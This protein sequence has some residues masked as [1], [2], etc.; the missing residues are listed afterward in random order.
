MSFEPLRT[1][2]GSRWDLSSP[3]TA[4]K[5]SSSTL[6][7][8][9]F[10]SL[11]RRP[12]GVVLGIDVFHFPGTCA[13]EL[14]CGLFI[15]INV[16][17]G[18]P[19]SMD[20]TRVE[21]AHPAYPLIIR[22]L[23]SDEAKILAVLNGRTYRYVFTRVYDSKTNL[24]VGAQKVEVDELPR[25]G[26]TFTDNV[27][28]YMEHLSQLGLAGVYQEGNQIALHDEQGMQTGVRVI[29]NYRLTDFGRRFVTSCTGN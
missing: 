20:S 6:V 15:Y 18:C 1:K 23:S 4:P 13:V 26:L 25:D 28:F 9:D 29:S 22:Q 5:G 21:E 19:R 24:F 7:K 3:C 10:V 12:S 27:G 14:D 8:K 17:R 2:E 16:V 11:L